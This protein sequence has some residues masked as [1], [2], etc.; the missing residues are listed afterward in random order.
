MPVIPGE[1]PFH[2]DTGSTRI[3]ARVTL[4][5]VAIAIACAI[6]PGESPKSLPVLAATGIASWVEWLKPLGHRDGTRE[7]ALY[8]VRR[9]QR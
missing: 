9:G 4:S 1:K 8:L 2:C 5:T 6:S 7:A 3:H